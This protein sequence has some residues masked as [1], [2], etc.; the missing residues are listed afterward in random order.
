M[1]LRVPVSPEVLGWALERSVDPESVHD[2][3]PKFDEWLEGT[4]Q[5]TVKQLKSFASRTGTPFGY[6]FLAAPPAL[7]LPVPDFR[8]GFK[9]GGTWR[10]L[11]RPPGSRAPEYPPPRLVSGLR[12]R[13]RPFEGRGRGRR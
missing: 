1:P 11:S 7:T 6:L 5:P 3:F 8:E 12:S 10:P 13:Q 4:A 2:A 9:G